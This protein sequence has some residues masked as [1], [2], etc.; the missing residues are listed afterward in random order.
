MGF[1]TGQLPLGRL[2][3]CIHIHVYICIR[4]QTC[5]QACSDVICE[6]GI[7]IRV[8]HPELCEI[9]YYSSV[10]LGLTPRKSPLPF[11]FFCRVPPSP[12]LLFLFSFKSFLILPCSTRW[13]ITVVPRVGNS[14]SPILLKKRFGPIPGLLALK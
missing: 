6:R 13:G 8:S 2:C 14:R 10:Q 12:H 1:W 11:F 4:V 7:I 9:K 5:M 3:V